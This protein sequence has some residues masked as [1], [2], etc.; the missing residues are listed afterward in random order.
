MKFRAR[1]FQ[2]GGDHVIDIP[3]HIRRHRDRQH[4]L[5]LRFFG[6]PGVHPLTGELVERFDLSLGLAFDNPT[7]AVFNI[8]VK[9]IVIRIVVDIRNIVFVINDAERVIRPF[10]ITV[11]D[12]TDQIQ[13]LSP[14]ESE[15]HGMRLILPLVGN[16]RFCQCERFTVERFDRRHTLQDNRGLFKP[17]A[18][19]ITNFETASDNPDTIGFPKH[20]NAGCGALLIVCEIPH[21]REQTAKPLGAPGNFDPS[22]FVK[23]STLQTNARGCR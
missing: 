9:H 23:R 5:F 2:P 10:E 11:A 14:F 15:E 4:S 22:S 13:H 18:A 16:D 20:T 1:R 6:I 21:F 3:R 7:A 19:Q 12:R 8:F 17:I